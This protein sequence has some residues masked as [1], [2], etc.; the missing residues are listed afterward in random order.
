M[1]FIQPRK[2]TSPISGEPVTPRLRTYIRNGKEVV[3]AEYIDPA[4]GTFI[5]KGIVSVKDIVKPEQNK[6]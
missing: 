2:I 3:E 5:R 1:D 4:S 6:E